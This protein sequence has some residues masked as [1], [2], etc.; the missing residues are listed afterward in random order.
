M[1]DT[2]QIVD[3][4]DSNLKGGPVATLLPGNAPDLGI[5]DIAHDPRPSFP[6]RPTLALAGLLLIGMAAVAIL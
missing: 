4:S 6:W 1:L 2:A 5:E 3:L